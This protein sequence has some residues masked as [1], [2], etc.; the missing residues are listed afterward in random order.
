MARGPVPNAQ[1]TIRARDCAD[2]SQRPLLIGDVL[3]YRGRAWIVVGL[4]MGTDPITSEVEEY[5]VLERWVTNE[6][7]AHEL[8]G[9]DQRGSVS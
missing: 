2:R 4:F 6:S 8:E 3:G 5:L 7:E 1:I 9:R